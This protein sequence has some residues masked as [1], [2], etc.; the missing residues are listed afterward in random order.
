MMLSVFIRQTIY[1]FLLVVILSIIVFG[2]RPQKTEVRELRPGQTI[3]RMI[4]R[5]ETHSYKFSLKKDEFF[6]VRDEQFVINLSLKLLDA[7]GNT[8]IDINSSEAEGYEMLSFVAPEFGS[9][10][11]ELIARATDVEKGNY[12][13]KR[14]PARVAST[15]DRRRVEVQRLFNEGINAGRQAEIYIKNLPKL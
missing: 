13:L 1:L 2:Q 6:H 3:T 12:I 8:L 4:R 9:F 5:A 15:K 14:E 10:V 7:R 11:L